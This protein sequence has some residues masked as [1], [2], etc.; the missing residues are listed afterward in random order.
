MK[1]DEFKTLFL[2]ICIIKKDVIKLDRSSLA[3]YKCD[4]FKHKCARKYLDFMW[5]Y[6]WGDMEYIE[7]MMKCWKK[8]SGRRS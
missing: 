1:K 3:Q 2:S 4:F 6:I 7:M 8:L 5:E